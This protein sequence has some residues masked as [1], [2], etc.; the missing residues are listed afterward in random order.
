MMVM[1]IA[2]MIQKVEN[3]DVDGSCCFFFT[4]FFPGDDEGVCAGD[5]SDENIFTFRFT[6]SNLFLCLFTKWQSRLFSTLI[7]RL[8][9]PFFPSLFSYLVV[10]ILHH[11]CFLLILSLFYF[12]HFFYSIFPIF[13]FFF[14]ILFLLFFM[15]FLF[16]RIFILSS[17]YFFILFYIFS[18]IYFSILSFI[19]FLPSRNK[20]SILLFFQRLQ[21]SPGVPQL[22]PS[23]P[24]QPY[25]SA[26]RSAP[27]LMTLL[28]PDTDDTRGSHNKAQGRQAD[29]S[30]HDRLPSSLV[31]RHV[32]GDGLRNFLSSTSRE[33]LS[34]ASH[35]C[36]RS[37]S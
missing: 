5:D 23:P 25:I 3:D 31:L 15:L 7:F 32:V 9:L 29:P 33:S 1:M 28:R 8:F 11:S 20:C 35:V 30:M 6:S 17:S 16:G 34:L 27:P 12:L 22:D 19:L 2:M 36:L 10:F 37:Y 14:L 21:E 4:F 13:L 18:F 26:P 24:R